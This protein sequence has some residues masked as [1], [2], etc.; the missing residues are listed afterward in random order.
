MNNNRQSQ[1]SPFGI[2]YGFNAACFGSTRS[3]C[4][5]NKTPKQLLCKLHNIILHHPR[6]W[7]RSQL[8]N[9][10]KVYEMPKQL[11]LKKNM[12][13]PISVIK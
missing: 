2:M 1:L 7:F 6:I 5:A 4:Q 11:K 13:F 10:I 8:T 3:H 9:I 12:L